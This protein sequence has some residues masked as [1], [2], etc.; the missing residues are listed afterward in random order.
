MKKGIRGPITGRGV[1]GTS[2]LEAGVGRGK[3]RGEKGLVVLLGKKFGVKD[4]TN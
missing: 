4:I 1:G 3:G 2:G